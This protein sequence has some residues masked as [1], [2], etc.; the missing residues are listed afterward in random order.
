MTAPDPEMIERVLREHS[1]RQGFNCWLG[2]ELIRAR[3][4]TVEITIPIKPDICQHHG[5]VHGGVAGALAD[6]A[7]AWA[8]ATAVGD[9]VT[10]NLTLQYLAPAKGS[11]L[12]ATATVLKAGKRN[13]S[14][15]ARVFAEAAGEEPKLVA[16]ALA[17]I[18]KTGV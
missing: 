16:V 15:E 12:R 8:A 11:R 17:M 9:V 6:T 3:D 13:V 2:V 14:V 10:S 18:A 7:C 1:G 5:Y 4:G